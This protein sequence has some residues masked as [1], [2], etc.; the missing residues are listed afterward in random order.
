MSERDLIRD[1]FAA[2]GARRADVPCGVGD[3]CALLAVPPDRQLAVSIDTL[4]AGVHFFADCDPQ[5]LGHKSLAVGLSDLA[6][7]GAEPAWATLALTL[8]E[9]DPDWLGGF[10][11]GLGDL[12]AAHGVQLVGGDT[13]RGP[14]TVSIQVHGLVA[15]GQAVTR[16][17]ARPG[18]LVCVSGTLGD[19]GLALRQLAAGKAPSATLRRRLERPEPRVGLGRR[20]AG[21]ASAMIDL[22][23]GLAGDLGHILAA[24]GVGADLELAALPLG[25]EGATVVAETGDWA[26]PLAS[27]DDYELCF[28]TPAARRA[29]LSAL[30]TP[31][32]A[33]T[34]IGQITAAPGLRCRE[35]NGD[36]WPLDRSGYDHFST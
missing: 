20:L 31:D 14:L 3:D 32:C 12:A 10:A 23:D 25:P 7:M 26:L 30:A 18:D 17:G 2:L 24:S 19:A 15:P 6:S 8:P 35:P 33:V 27:G 34:V 28:T 21:L 16:A 5:A 36:L 11:R 1:Y 29:E 22:S 13:T 9:I 4:V